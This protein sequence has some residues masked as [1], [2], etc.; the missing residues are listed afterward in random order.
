MPF[1][2]GA[3][4]FALQQFWGETLNFQAPSRARSLPISAFVITLNEAEKIGDC[5]LSLADCAEIILVD[6]G[7]EDRTV[8]IANELAVEGLPVK[9]FHQTWL[10]YAA[11]KQFALE[12][13]SMPWCLSIDADERMDAELRE[14][15][16]S[17]VECD[18]ATVGWRLARRG[19]LPGFGYTPTWVRERTKLR[20][21]R[22]GKGSFGLNRLVHEKINPDGQ[23]K[24][25]RKGS[26]LHYTPQLID[27]Q[28][29]K[30]NKY[31]SL[32]A[33]MIVRDGQ[34]RHPLRLIISPVLY[35]FRL[36]VLHGLW[37][38]G[39]P[40]YIQAATGAVYSFLTEAKVY[41][42][43]ATAKKG[44]RQ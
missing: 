21:I 34:R 18:E 38:C 6:C 8:A 39:F 23:V 37:R 10:G 22:N 40:G 9:V 36:Y 24:V 11:Q 1:F 42:R 43:R 3:D 27:E 32:K 25:A 30:E 14:S 26:F 44:D 7:S 13:C 20:L 28:I 33:E 35:F 15:L 17:L 19:F 16:A 5:L 41:Q 2:D 31:S 4:R 12:K 29:L